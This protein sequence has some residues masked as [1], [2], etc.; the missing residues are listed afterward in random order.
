[1]AISKNITTKVF[2]WFAGLA[3]KY[4]RL[5]RGQ[6]KV[7]LRAL[8]NEPGRSWSLCWSLELVQGGVMGKL[9]RELGSEGI[10]VCKGKGLQE[11]PPRNWLLA[12][13]VPLYS[14]A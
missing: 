9:L 12:S 11:V 3:G 1:M 8:R 5:S 6:D 7:K 2:K 13:H 4:S 14:E 10:M